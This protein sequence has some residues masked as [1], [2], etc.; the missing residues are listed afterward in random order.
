MIAETMN[1]MFHLIL[2]LSFSGSLLIIVLLCLRP[3][4]RKWFSKKWQYYIWLAVI[5]RLLLPFAPENN[6]YTIFIQPAQHSIRTPSVSNSAPDTEVSPVHETRSTD[7]SAEHT[8]FLAAVMQNLWALWLLFSITLFIRKLTLYQSFL[9][10]IKAGRTEVS[11]IR[12]L[13][14]LSLLAGQLG[15]KAHVELCTHS[16]ISSPLLIGF[17]RP[18]IVLPDMDITDSEFHYIVLHELTHYRRKDILYKWLAQIAICFHWFNPLVHLMGREINRLCELSC[19]EAVISRLDTKGRRSYGD[20]LLH[21][22][23]PGNG[24]KSSYASVTLNNGKELLKERL[25]AIMYYKKTPGRILCITASMTV[26]F[27]FAAYASGT[28]GVSAD[29][30]PKTMAEAE[31][32]AP[33]DKTFPDNYFTQAGYY[34]SPYIFDFGWNLNTDWAE[35]YPDLANITLSDDTVVTVFFASS[36]AEYAG[37]QDVL[38][39]LKGLIERLS[40]QTSGSQP[41]I[42][43]PLV[44]SVTETGENSLEQLAEEYYKNGHMTK[45]SAIFPALD[46]DLQKDF[47]TRIIDDG[48]LTYLSSCAGSMDFELLDYCLERSYEEQRLTLF[49][50]LVPHLDKAQKKEW[51]ARASKDERNTFLSVLLKELDEN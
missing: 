33:A 41:S 42:K 17:F 50:V 9:N 44:T 38:T 8:P 15:I 35:N 27:S 12:L 39:A 11:D 22:V 45:F 31:A 4:S 23:K 5:A 43:S 21:A 3:A 6:L 34:Q 16:L 30:G 26:L 24:L 18:C 13:D 19:D 10:Y 7:V 49:A 32:A 1:N 37:N 47:C 51:T 48:K 40:V 2:L 28:S 25:E 46:R 14:Q 36:C 29:P 20:T